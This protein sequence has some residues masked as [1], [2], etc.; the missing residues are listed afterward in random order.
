M[1]LLAFSVACHSERSEE[2]ILIAFYVFHAF[3]FLKSHVFGEEDGFFAPFHY[4]QNDKLSVL[5]ARAGRVPIMSA[6]ALQLALNVKNG[7]RDGLSAAGLKTCCQYDV[8]TE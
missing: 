5:Q 2:S 6:W 3:L 7:A 1:G 4:A 8:D